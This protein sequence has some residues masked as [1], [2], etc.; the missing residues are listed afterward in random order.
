LPKQ[1]FRSLFLL[2][3]LN[4]LVKPVWVFAI[5]RVVQYRVGMEAYGQY[6][7]LFNLSLIFS[8]LLDPGLTTFNNRRV[9][10]EGGFQWQQSNAIIRLKIGLAVLYGTVLLLVALISGA[11]HL[12]LLLLLA[13]NQFLL[14]FLLFLR[15]N[16]TG[17]Q[18]FTTDAWL[19]V[20][21]KIMVI[22]ACGILL[23]FPAVAGGITL[24]RFVGIQVIAL[25]L[26]IAATLWVLF[27]ERSK[28]KPSLGTL[29]LNRTLLQQ[30]WPY[31]LIVFL[32]SAH[33]R[34]DAFLLERLHP[35]GAWEAGLY[36]ASFRLL[37]IFNM[38]GYLIASFLLPFVAKNWPKKKTVADAS[39]QSRHL[40]MIFSIGVVMVSLLLSPVLYP[41]LYKGQQ[42][43]DLRVVKWCLAALPAYA[44]V[45]IYG[46][47]L[48][49]TGLIRVFLRI[50][51]LVV[52]LN[53]LLTLWL[54]P[55]EGALGAAK[56]ACIS[57]AIYAVL[58]VITCKRQLGISYGI[59]SLLKYAGL[60]VCLYLVYRLAIVTGIEQVMV[61]LCLL[62]IAGILYSLLLQLFTVS[63]WRQLISR[64]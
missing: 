44:L 59:R 9:A 52:V 64:K 2:L 39:L 11:D 12:P 55:A 33:S 58:L 45:H 53:I 14:S 50:T 51:A 22:I 7:A 26:V 35:N 19:S 61:H 48:T 30:A 46:S 40:L 25:L 6:F 10:K 28:H 20:A 1:F 3:F 15:S 31:A 34:A 29:S 32:M 17:L 57:Q 47:L 27:R 60:P 4:L 8:F 62:M 43:V 16:I 21:D 54:I 18:L 13:L 56:S 41:M 37:D 49:A 5:D 42:N 38:P 36:A 63:Q 24:Q 23:Y